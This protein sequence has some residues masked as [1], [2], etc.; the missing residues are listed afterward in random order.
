MRLLISVT[1]EDEARA[2]LEGGADII[3]AKDPSVGPL[4]AV[5]IVTLREIVRVVDGRRPVSAALGDAVDEKQVS[6]AARRAAAERLAYIKIGF[7]GIADADR[8][9]CLIGS[10]VYGA[11][12]V[13]SSAGVIAVAYADCGRPGV[14]SLSPWWLVEAAE[15]AGAVGVLLDTAVKASVASREDEQPGLFAAMSEGQVAEWVRHARSADL[16]VAVAGGLTGAE[17]SVI[18]AIGVDI[19]GV[20]SAACERG[21]RLGCVTRERVAALA[22]S[23]GRRS[24]PASH[25]VSWAAPGRET[26]TSRA[27]LP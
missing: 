9:E 4:G 26:T 2:A 1:N 7:A 5:D 3:D 10:A 6:L 27:G 8:V 17:L 11:G 16:T 21:E 15:R 12:L 22:R 24:W 20:R 13:S 25:V 23:A 19:A 18:R 14:A